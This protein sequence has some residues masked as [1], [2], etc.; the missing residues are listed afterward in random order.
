MEQRTRKLVE[1]A[2]LGS[3]LDAEW[4]LDGTPLERSFAF[5][6]N[7]AGLSQTFFDL[8]GKY[9]RQHYNGI[10]FNNRSLQADFG[11]R[12]SGS[13]F[14]LI[15]ATYG[16][17]IDYANSRPGTRWLIEPEAELKLGRNLALDLSHAFEYLQVEQG[18]LY[19]ANISQA[20]IMY[21]FSRRM[22]VR[23][24]LQYVNYDRNTDIYTFEI[25]RESKSLFSQFLFSYKINPQTVLYLG[26]SDNYNGD[27]SIGLTQANRTLFVKMGYALVM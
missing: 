7:Y 27:Q 8:N 15:N 2:Q 14:L 3:G 12:P 10:E 24:I 17:Q 19:T 26:Y 1:Y 18:R 23:T 9:R 4:D 13:V 20:R 21:S 25:D 5:W 6:F 16:D 22:F 11:I